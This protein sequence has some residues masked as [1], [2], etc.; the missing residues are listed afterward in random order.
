MSA[1]SQHLDEYLRLRQLLGH[2]LAHAA[3]L[4]PRFVSYLEARDM[5]FVTVQTTVDWSLEPEAPPRT[6]VWGRRFMVAR[7][8]ARYLSGIDPRTE[9]PSAGLIP[10][11]QQWRP[12]FIYAEDDI[13]ALMDEAG[14]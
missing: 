3:R 7:G 6:T 2:R 4:L 8:F 11:R 13:V 14:R 12:P 5:E 9:I 10:I 1:L